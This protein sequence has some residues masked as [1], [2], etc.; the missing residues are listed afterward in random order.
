MKE[1]AFRTRN[2]RTVKARNGGR[3]ER[4]AAP[5]LDSGSSKPYFSD[6]TPRN[7]LIERTK[8]GKTG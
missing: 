8:A 6:T 1:P 7:I 5:G 2:G 3:I 4:G